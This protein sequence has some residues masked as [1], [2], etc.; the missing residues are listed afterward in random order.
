LII[1]SD[2]SLSTETTLHEIRSDSGVVPNV[3]LLAHWGLGTD[4]L[5][6]VAEST[7]NGLW[8][9]NLLTRFEEVLTLEDIF[10][11][12]F[13]EVVL[14]RNLTGKEGRRETGAILHSELLGG[15]LDGGVI[16]LLNTVSRGHFGVVN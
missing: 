1:N 6:S 11:R 10:G 14:G 8:H 3:S 2:Y 4:L 12:K 15:S 16:T 9:T 7:T 13:T 5:V